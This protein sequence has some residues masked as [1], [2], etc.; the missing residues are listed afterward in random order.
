V[1]ESVFNLPGLGPWLVSSLLSRDLPVVLGVIPFT[2]VLV[3][4]LNLLADILRGLLD[5]RFAQE[6]AA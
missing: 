2:V 4:L 1:V 5:P 6:R 3:V